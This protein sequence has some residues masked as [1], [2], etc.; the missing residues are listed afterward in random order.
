MISPC[1]D[2]TI[3]CL[4]A[5]PLP[6][7]AVVVFDLDD[8][9]Y[10]ERDFVRSGFRAVAALFGR[11]LET[12]VYRRLVDL[13]NDYHPDPFAVVLSDLED[14]ADRIDKS[15]MMRAYRE[16]RP[17]LTLSTDVAG[18]LSNLRSL[19][20]SLAIITDGR[21]V[22]QRNKFFAL[23]LDT[24]IDVIVISEELGAAKPNPRAYESI[25]RCFPHGPYV[26]VGND[27]TKDFIAP[28]RLGWIT[29]GLVDDGRQLR[30]SEWRDYP[31]RTNRTIGSTNWHNLWRRDDEFGAEPPC[32][33]TDYP[34]HVAAGI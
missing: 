1:S 23:G 34:S 27:V 33:V 32:F 3:T 10:L 18:L 4:S 29:I 9:L 6:D 21:S 7:R 17:S 30:S 20:R 26:Y 13:F 11:E 14:R 31:V 25:E 24:W 8:T 16:H 2:T 12:E 19:D 28:N 22:T 15:R 5:V